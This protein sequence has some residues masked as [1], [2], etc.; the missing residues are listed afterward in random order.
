MLAWWVSANDKLKKTISNLANKENMNF[1]HP[2]KNLYCMDN[3]AMVWINAYYK[4]KY[5]K[6][7]KY[8]W[9]VSI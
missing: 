2:V 5:G 3:A 6:F 4:I 1:I 9:T 8:I 7:E